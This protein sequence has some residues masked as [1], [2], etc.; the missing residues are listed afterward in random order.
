MNVVDFPVMA[1]S[2]CFH[3]TGAPADTKFADTLR[4][5]DPGKPDQ[6][7]GRVYVCANC[8]QN[9][10]DVLGLFDPQKALVAEAQ[11]KVVALEEKLAAFTAVQAAI[12][13]YA[14]A[15]VEKAPR[16]KKTAQ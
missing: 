2:I 4:E 16:T 14:P 10:A 6:R 8:A 15:P 13:A 5:Y 11:A 3:C 7:I 9:F 12:E 1:P